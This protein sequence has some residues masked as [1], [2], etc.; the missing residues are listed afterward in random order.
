MPH[1]WVVRVYLVYESHRAL[2]DLARIRLTACVNEMGQVLDW[3]MLHVDAKPSMQVSQM[4]CFHG[5]HPP[6]VAVA[7][8]YLHTPPNDCPTSFD[9]Q[10]APPGYIRR[11]D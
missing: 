10:L 6:W 4:A 3:T 1:A 8:H 2:G 7:P 5:P 9:W 11:V